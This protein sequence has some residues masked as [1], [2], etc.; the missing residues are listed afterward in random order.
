[1]YMP[2]GT[3]SR[4]LNN[5]CQSDM[6]TRYFFRAAIPNALSCQ[7]SQIYL[8]GIRLRCSCHVFPTVDALSGSG[9][10]TMK[11]AINM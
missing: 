10:Q 11:N 7:Y 3:V 2:N 8:N 1:M 6:L 4:I 5:S 9:R